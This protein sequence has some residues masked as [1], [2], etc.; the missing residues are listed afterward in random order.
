VPGA[1]NFLSILFELKNPNSTYGVT[2]ISYT[3]TVL[4]NGGE[5]K[6][7]INRS[8]FLYP[9]EIRTVL[10]VGIPLAASGVASADV[11]LG[12]PEWV[13]GDIFKM[14]TFETRGIALANATGGMTVTGVLVNKSS[15]HIASVLIGVFVGERTLPKGVSQTSV[16]DVAPFEERAF[17]I[18]VPG[19]SKETL[20]PSELKIFLAALKNPL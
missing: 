18:F 8:T 6:Q 12:A 5:V 19:V 20:T 11:S 9:A 3:I 1:E 7:A 4:G 17:S 16:T 13:S 2:K 14:P 15:E 10:E